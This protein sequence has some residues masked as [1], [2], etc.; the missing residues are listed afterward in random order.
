M[1]GIWLTGLSLGSFGELS[2]RAYA[3]DFWTAMTT[4][5]APT[6]RYSHVAVWTGSK[7]IVWGGD[8]GGSGAGTTAG[9]AN[10]GGMYDPVANSWVPTTTTGAPSRRIWISAV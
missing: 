8:Q 7:C 1:V 5:G 3:S 4:T 10:T 9:F 2:A 6:A